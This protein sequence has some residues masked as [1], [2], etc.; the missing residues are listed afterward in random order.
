MKLYLI[1]Y[2]NYDIEDEFENINLLIKHI[3]RVLKDNGYFISR[4]L[5]NKQII[6]IYEQEFECDIHS[7]EKLEDTK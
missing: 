5:D 6:K 4:M 7:Y 2:H 3:T 1:T